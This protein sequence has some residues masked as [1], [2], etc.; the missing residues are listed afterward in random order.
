MLLG[1][2]GKKKKRKICDVQ[3]EKNRSIKIKTKKIPSCS[4]LKEE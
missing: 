1:T 4:E 2:T 3:K